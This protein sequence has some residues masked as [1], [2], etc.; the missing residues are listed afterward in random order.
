MKLIAPWQPVRPLILT[1]VLGLAACGSDAP[2]VVEHA[3]SWF[4][5]LVASDIEAE[6][7]A[8]NF[9]YQV[10][11]ERM[12]EAERILEA[13]AISQISPGE[14]AYFAGQPVELPD[15]TRPYLIRGLYR[16]E[17]SFSVHI[18]DNALWVVSHDVPADSAPMQRQPL[19]LIMD[20]V[21]ARVFVTTGQ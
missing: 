21:P 2:D 7:I 11:P 19:L 16:T 18:V 17:R 4:N 15:V 13:I 1:A 9:V 10:M 6:L 12:A 3:D 14:A 5:A 20:E 8:P